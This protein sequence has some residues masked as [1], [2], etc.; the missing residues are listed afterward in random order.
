[1]CLYFLF[2]LGSSH[3]ISLYSHKSHH[4]SS[5][6]LLSLSESLELVNFLKISLNFMVDGGRISAPLVDIR[7]WAAI[8]PTL[9]PNGAF[10]SLVGQECLAVFGTRILSDRF[11]SIHLDGLS[12]AVHMSL[13]FGYHICFLKFLNN[14]KCVFPM[15]G[16]IFGLLNSLL[17]PMKT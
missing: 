14:K 5:V 7:V 16:A 9:L 4:L 15:N 13:F 1:M 2:G 3:I 17:I 11:R 8:Q 6:T 12:S 10:L